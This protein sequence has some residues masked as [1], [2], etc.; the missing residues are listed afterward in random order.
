MHFLKFFDQLIGHFFEKLIFLFSLQNKKNTHVL[1][2]LSYN[3]KIRFLFEKY[4]DFLYV[5]VYN[6][7]VQLY[8]RFKKWMLFIKI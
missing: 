8:M 2:T 7:S 3:F 5:L 4:V 6:N 1:M